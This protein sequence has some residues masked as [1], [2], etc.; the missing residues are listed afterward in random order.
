MG[1]PVF[2]STLWNLYS[3]DRFWTKVANVKKWT[4]FGKIWRWI[5]FDVPLHKIKV[6]LRDL[7]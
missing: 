6:V 5:M 4:N 3:S 7:L 1:L 2:Y